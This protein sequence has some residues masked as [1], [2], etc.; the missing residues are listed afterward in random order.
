VRL[1]ALADPLDALQLRVDHQRPARAVGDDRRVLEGQPV[2]GEAL[3][4]PR[5]HLRLVREHLE[6]VDALDVRA[7]DLAVLQVGQPL[8]AQQLRAELAVERPHVGDEGRRHHRVAH[9]QLLLLLQALHVGAPPLVLVLEAVDEALGE[10]EPLGG[11]VGRLDEAVLLL[12]RL[13]EREDRGEAQR[14][15]EMRHARCER[16]G[17]RREARGERR[18]A[19]GER[20]EERGEERGGGE[21]EREGHNHLHELVLQQ[22]LALL[23]DGHLLAHLRGEGHTTVRRRGHTT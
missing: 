9:Q 14:R 16:R 8:V 11:A 18:E 23:E 1:L 10:V 17:E 15:G 6:H 2:G 19:R 7:R 12:G 21:R 4:L 20:R 22:P 13:H 5:R 3:A